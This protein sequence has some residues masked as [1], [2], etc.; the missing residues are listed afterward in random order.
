MKRFTSFISEAQMS[1]AAEQA[2][3]LGLKSDGHGN[4]IDRQGKVTART[5]GGKLQFL[6]KKGPKAAEDPKAERRPSGVAAPAPAKK[7]A[8]PEPQKQQKAAPE[9]EGGEGGENILTVV[10]GR[11]NPPTVG[12]EKLLKSAKQVSAGGDIKIYPSRSQDPKKNPLD[13]DEK[14]SYMKKMFP[15][16]KD[17]I[18][19]DPEMKTIFNVLVAADEDGYDSVTIVVGSDRQAEF[20]NLATKYNGEL[21]NF[22]NIRV[23][24][25]GVRD[26]DAEGVEGMSASKMRKAVADDDFKAFRMGTPKSLNDADT[27]GLFDATR[28]GLK[29]GKAKKT[30]DD[31]KKEEW[32]I[33]PKL[34]PQTL[35]ENYLTGKIFKM[36]D[37]VESLNTGLVGKITRRGT[38]HLICVTEE[39]IM[40]KSWV[41]D[42]TEALGSEKT[43]PAGK[44][45]TL[46][47]TPGYTKL[48]MKMT[49]TKKIKNFNVEE[50][51]NKYML[52]K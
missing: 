22:E 41:S 48:T 1:Q 11:F 28:R 37:L 43:R 38:N 25:A 52:K 5:E 51:L 31:T 49:G 44:P 29:L 23:V 18:V 24:S 47:G 12:H 46:V 27:Q 7:A 42:L 17:D 2:R 26:A 39:G 9:E 16:F 21:Y 32:Q 8:A 36:G 3:K 30:E 13:P 40:F 45:N 4:W 10:F 19:N 20:E 15:D 33:A 14:A 35:R 6:D 50:L 34:F